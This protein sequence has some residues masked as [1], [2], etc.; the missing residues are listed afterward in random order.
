MRNAETASLLGCV[1][2]PSTPSPGSR[3]A[4]SRKTPFAISSMACL[5]GSWISPPVCTTCAEPVDAI[6]TNAR[7]PILG[8]LYCQQTTD[9]PVR[10]GASLKRRA[11]RIHVT[12]RVKRLP[13]R[14]QAGLRKIPRSVRIQAGSP[15]AG[16][17]VGRS[18]SVRPVRS[19][20]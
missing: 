19:A 4:A 10:L 16:G 17:A 3:S 7:T 20:T 6:G 9:R 5:I 14:A 18:H 1:F 2:E 11:E 8:R 13:G 15:D 12:E